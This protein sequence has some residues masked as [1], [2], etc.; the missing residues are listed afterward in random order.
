MYSLYFENTTGYADTKAVET[1]TREVSKII[2][3][4]VKQSIKEVQECK[5]AVKK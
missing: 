1:I 3:E 2:T 5:E 4:Q